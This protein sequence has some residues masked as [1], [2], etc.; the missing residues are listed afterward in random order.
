MMI[1]EPKKIERFGIY[2][3]GNTCYM[4]SSI[5]FLRSVP[6]LNEMMKNTKLTNVSTFITQP[7]SQAQVIG[8]NLA[9]VVKE[10]Q[11]QDVTPQHFVGLFL[12]CHP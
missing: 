4:N 8:G 6:A 7:T 12:N 9:G 5:Q 11:K 3:I 1:E 2:N 10:L